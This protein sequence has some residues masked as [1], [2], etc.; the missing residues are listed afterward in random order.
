[1][2]KPSTYKIRNRLLTSTL[3]ISLFAFNA[4]A[5]KD[6]ILGGKALKMNHNGNNGGKEYFKVRIDNDQDD[7]DLVVKV[8]EGDISSDP[9]VYIS[10]V[11]SRYMLIAIE[12]LKSFFMGRR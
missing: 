10:K 8:I 3:I 5:T 12:K 6:L 1:M 2:G 4:V 9:D 7:A 11:R